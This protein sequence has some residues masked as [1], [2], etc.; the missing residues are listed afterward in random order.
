MSKS[1]T[2]VY[3]GSFDPITQ[4]HLDLVRRACRLF[5]TVILAVGE[6]P[7]KRTLMELD[8]RLAVLRECTADLPE[9]KVDAFQG[10]LVDYCKEVGASAILRG[11]RAVSDFDFEFQIGLANMDMAP[12]VETV[13]LLAEP[14]NIFISSSLVKE[15][16]SNGGDVSR[17]VPPAALEAL[18]RA[19]KR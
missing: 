7:A 13:F 8:E 14:R 19:L 18:H 17:Y 2:A 6:N 15:I 12:E 10:L 11:L 4:G 9:V 16:A 3:A 5:D 1:G